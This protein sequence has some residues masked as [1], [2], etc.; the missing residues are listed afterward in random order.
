MKYLSFFRG[1]RKKYYNHRQ[2]ARA[3][4]HSY[5][6]III[7]GMDQNKTNIPH[8]IH[9]TKSSHNLWRLR[10]HLT[11]VLIHTKPAMGKL[12]YGF[13]D[14]MQFSHDSNLTINV[15]LKVLTDLCSSADSLP[16]VLYLQLDN[17]FREN[18]NKYLFS[19][20]SLLIQRKVFEKVSYR[21]IIY[22]L[23]II[24]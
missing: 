10:T 18:K 2:K 11:G 24:G 7:D 13:Y 12:A 23:S 3:N 14:I 8:L 19:F 17:C 20:C 6:A 22:K 5:V 16:K 15:L 1:E 9:S 4:P 21:I